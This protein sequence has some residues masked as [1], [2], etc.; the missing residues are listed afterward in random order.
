MIRI[1]LVDDHTMVRE[2]LRVVLERESSIQAVAEAGDG[3]S[4]L[5]MVVT[6]M[7]DVVLLD[8]SLPGISGIET[9]R[10]MRSACPDIK[11]LALSTYLEQGVIQQMLEAGADGYISKSEAGIELMQG[12]RSV[13]AGH[14]YLC[15]QAAMLIAESL[16]KLR[17][18][19]GTSDQRSLSPRE[20]QVATLLAE[21]MSAIDI[22]AQLNISP[23]TVEVHRRNLMRKLELHSVV[24]L[25]RYA[26]RTGLI[27]A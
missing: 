15:P 21:G 19:T 22:A 14:N 1:L 23:N 17:P 13:L 16:R 6:W 10:R 25:T 27:A 4:A 20:L 18:A 2:A 5:R 8:V 11:A 24:D 12:I 7:P 9:M 3:E 26:I